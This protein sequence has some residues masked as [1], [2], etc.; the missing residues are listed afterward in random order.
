MMKDTYHV[1]AIIEA[2]WLTRKTGGAELVIYRKG[3]FDHRQKPNTREPRKWLNED[4][5]IKRIS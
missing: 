3:R 2:Y 5:I 4:I 1:I